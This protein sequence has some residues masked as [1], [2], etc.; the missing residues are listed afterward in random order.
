MTTFGRRSFTCPICQT[1]FVDTV[2]TSIMTYIGVLTYQ[3][4]FHTFLS[5][6]GTGCSTP[7]NSRFDGISPFET[8]FYNSFW[9]HFTAPLTGYIHQCPS[10]MFSFMDS[11]FSASDALREYVLSR[12]IFED[13]DQETLETTS[14]QFEI[15]GRVLVFD[16]VS[17]EQIAWAYL[18]AS[19][20][21][22]EERN[23]PNEK[24]FQLLAANYFEKAILEKNL[25]NNEAIEHIKY[26][27]GE[28]YR[29]AGEFDVAIEWFSRVNRNHPRAETARRQ[30]SLA[31]Q[32][33]SNSSFFEA[34]DG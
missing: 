23:C 10:C 25:K 20:Q 12:E 18:W 2:V 22:R 4:I 32:Q 8:D 7:G 34:V 9:M 13:M 17:D 29:R 19:W 28:L 16:Q 6:Y 33:N 31:E 30:M 11:E 3:Q 1:V 26:L 21:A 15:F 5:L 14:S 24:R 27:I